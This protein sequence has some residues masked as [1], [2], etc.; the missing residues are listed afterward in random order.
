MHFTVDRSKWLHGEGA[1]FSQL[2]RPSDEKMC[3][4]GFRAIQSGASRSDLLGLGT[5][6]SC[7]L[8]NIPIDL[9]LLLSPKRRIPYNG[10]Q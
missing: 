6:R 4:L 8:R 7:L 3:C 1:A 9:G 5:P 10:C 2:L